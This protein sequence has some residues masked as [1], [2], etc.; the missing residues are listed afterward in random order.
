[1]DLEPI[2]PREMPVYD[3]ARVKERLLLDGYRQA[4]WRFE[5]A[6]TLEDNQRACFALFEALNWAHALDDL[7]GEVFRPEGKRE[8]EG[9]RRWVASG[10]GVLGAFRWVRNRVHHQ[11][12]DAPVEHPGPK[13]ILPF[14]GGRFSGVRPTV[15]PRRI[16]ADVPSLWAGSCT[17]SASPGNPPPMRCERSSACSRT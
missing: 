13:K 17:N 15:C 10:E 16:R 3:G 7:I 11:W 12:A 14:D 8:G 6:A 9:W 4:M 5:D 1:M 2:M